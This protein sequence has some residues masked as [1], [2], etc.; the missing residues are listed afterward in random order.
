MSQIP[1]GYRAKLTMG[2][3]QEMFE[4]QEEINEAMRNAIIELAAHVKA[5]S[6]HVAQLN[7]ALEVI[8]VR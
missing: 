6:D 4:L 7:T 8:N 1:K 5:L 3:V 2:D